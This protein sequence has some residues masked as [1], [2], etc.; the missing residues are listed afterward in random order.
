M[1]KVLLLILSFLLT[2]MAFSADNTQLYAAGS[3]KI[4]F[5]EVIKAY[6]TEY[7]QSVSTKFA[8]S[9]L[10]RKSIEEG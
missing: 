10:L 6:E 4:A 3:S 8:P 5:S 1:K 2:P 7:L 9:G